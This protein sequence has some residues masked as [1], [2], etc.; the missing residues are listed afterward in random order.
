MKPVVKL[1]DYLETLDDEKDKDLI[2]AIGAESCFFFIGTKE[3]FKNDIYFLNTYYKNYVDAIYM[4]AIDKG[5]FDF[6][7]IKSAKDAITERGVR[8]TI[9][10]L[11]RAMYESTRFTDF[12][13]R[14]VFDAFYSTDQ[15][16][17]VIKVSGPV[18]AKAWTKDEYDAFRKRN[19]RK[20]HS[21]VEEV[22]A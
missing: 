16:R 7:Q 20:W 4:N 15:H 21:I 12:R 14:T 22:S 11:Y 18:A 17:M 13:E 2:L 1:K 5:K 19:K 3:E 8:D 10:K 9:T 6:A